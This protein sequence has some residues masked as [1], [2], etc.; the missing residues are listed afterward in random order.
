MTAY[1]SSNAHAEDIY[2][3][4]DAKSRRINGLNYQLSGGFVILYDEPSSYA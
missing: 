2:E 1:R 3:V 4:T